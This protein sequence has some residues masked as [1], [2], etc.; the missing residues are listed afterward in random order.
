MEFANKPKPSICLDYERHGATWIMENSNCKLMFDTR[1]LY[2][3]YLYDVLFHEIGHHVE[4]ISHDIKHKT[5]NQRE[6]FA[7]EFGIKKRK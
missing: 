1:S 3:F 6:W 4:I 7:L 5:Y 2:S